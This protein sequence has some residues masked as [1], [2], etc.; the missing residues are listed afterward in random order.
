MWPRGFNLFI[1]VLL[2]CGKDGKHFYFPHSFWIF[3]GGCIELL[4]HWNIA[5]WCVWEGRGAAPPCTW[6]SEAMIPQ[7]ERPATASDHTRFPTRLTLKK[8]NTPTY[9]SR[10]CFV[11]RPVE[12]FPSGEKTLAEA[13]LRAVPWVRA[14]GR[15]R[16]GRSAFHGVGNSLTSSFSKSTDGCWTSRAACEP[17]AW[18]L[19]RA[20]RG[21]HSQWRVSKLWGSL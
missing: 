17:R 7:S 12:Q 10:F 11:I 9:C 16:G 1:S 20:S 19:Q 15:T 5:H 4:L 8:P 18:H 14:R 2:A 6:N 3:G 13:P 21:V